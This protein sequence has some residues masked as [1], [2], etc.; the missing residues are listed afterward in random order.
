MSSIVS[1]KLDSMFDMQEATQKMLGYSI[2]AMTAE[3]RTAYIKEYALH[4]EHEM[5]EMLQELPYFKKWKKYAID[6]DTCDDMLEKAQQEWADVTHF[7]LNISLALG[8]T[9]CMLLDMY[10]TKNKTNHNRQKDT[11]NY[12]PCTGG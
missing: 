2:D 5:H 12:K 9:P 11:D 10:A 6:N 8:F 4:M 3:E 7:F 1:D